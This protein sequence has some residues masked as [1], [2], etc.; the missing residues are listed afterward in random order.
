L[1]YSN[2]SLIADNIELIKRLARLE[3]IELADQ[4][5]GLRLANYGREAWIDIDAETLYQHQTNLE[6]RL[7]SV[8]DDIQKLESRLANEN[9]IKNAPEK[10]VEETKQ[11]LADKQSL[12]QRL[13][14]ELETINQ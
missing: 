10:L 5:R 6:N 7:A 14:R 8:R 9:Y 11:Q 13:E 1:L 12:E 4:A 3:S 2:D